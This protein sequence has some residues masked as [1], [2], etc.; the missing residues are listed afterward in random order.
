MSN[1]G[2]RFETKSRVK[3]LRTSLIFVTAA[4]ITLAATNSR[5]LSENDSGGFLYSHYLQHQTGE[6]ETFV[7][8]SPSSPRSPFWQNAASRVKHSVNELSLSD[9][10]A[11]QAF[12]GEHSHTQ[13]ELTDLG[14]QLG[15]DVI[16]QGALSAADELA[17]D[18]L[19]QIDVNIE[20]KSGRGFSNIG[21]DAITSLRE[22][23]KDVLAAQV[24]GYAGFDDNRR[25]GFNVGS[26]YRWVAND[27]TLLGANV[28][29]DYETFDGDGFWRLGAGA[30]SRSAWLDVFG[31]VY[32]AQTDTKIKDNGD[33]IYSASGYDVEAHVHSPKL[34]L[35]A[36]VVGAYNWKG[37]QG[38]SNEDGFLLGARVTPLQIPLLMQVDYRTGE[39][40]SLGGRFVFNY[41]FNKTGT[42]FSHARG[43]VF[44]PQ[45]YFYAPVEREYTQRI[46]VGKSRLPNVARFIGMESGG[47]VLRSA[48]SG[49]TVTV[50]SVANDSMIEL[51]G[52]LDGADLVSSQG[53]AAADRMFDLSTWFPA[54]ANVELDNNSG[55]VIVMA[56]NSDNASRA[57]LSDKAEV[58]VSE[59][60]MV[61]EQG[62]VSIQANE[63]FNL[64][65]GT[66]GTPAGIRIREQSVIE[67][68]RATNGAGQIMI[69]GSFVV[70]T[71]AMTISSIGNAAVSLRYNQSGD[72]MGN[73]TSISG[74]YRISQNGVTSNVDCDSPGTF[75]VNGPLAVMAA[76]SFPG[77]GT[78]NSPINAPLGYGGVIATVSGTGTSNASDE[79][80]AALSSPLTVNEN[81]VISVADN[82]TLS[83]GVHGIQIMLTRD[84]VLATSMVYVFVGEF[85]ASL[86]P[87]NGD[88]VTGQSTAN[89][90]F[91]FPINDSETAAQ[92]TRLARVSARGGNDVQY[93]YD[94]K[95][96]A[97]TASMFEVRN[98]FLEVAQNL[99]S[100]TTLTI[101]VEVSTN[102][103]NS[104]SP[105]DPA[106]EF[107][108]VVVVADI[109]FE[110]VVQT[111]LPGR[112]TST[113]PYRIEDSALLEVGSTLAIV[114]ASGAGSV[115]YDFSRN[116][117][118]IYDVGNG[119][120]SVAAE[121]DG[122]GSYTITVRATL[123]SSSSTMITMTVLYF[124]GLVAGASVENS[125][126]IA[127]AVSD[128]LANNQNYGSFI[129]ADGERVSV[130]RFDESK[131]RSG[132]L[133][134]D[135]V[136]SMKTDMIGFGH[137]N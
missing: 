85:A 31:N 86:T 133:L 63:G 94:I 101:I 55:T 123:T 129:V 3:T 109:P 27:N 120:V 88:G 1:I 37:K 122:G 116:S 128:E 110:L 75:C 84:G 17:G 14:S 21:L 50:V 96:A 112:G 57:E 4:V 51:R 132:A 39:G 107:A 28:F 25:H 60:A 126:F 35:L 20:T 130:S 41:E 48:E 65:M 13:Q 93:A 45:N 49:T 73:V 114:R 16:R 30:E 99:P 113:N 66:S 46:Q 40:E 11:K 18:W 7:I 117:N 97:A 72:L 36:G 95:G 5:A 136:I 24:H 131:L 124:R 33:A 76:S 81:G 89:N 69:A 118:I 53:L 83:A 103:S 34:P 44:R 134:N 115:S 137:S 74:A 111:N 104:N 108:V 64:M 98:G 15:A 121:L 119:V 12:N 47:A 2:M 92:G 79:I 32:S 9:I 62:Q 59:N 61:L 68:N 87:F 67:V 127:P 102:N 80:A 42:T 82:E 43:G 105:N 29:L 91:L 58:I 90:A 52:F 125:P 8:S 56:W 77:A 106:R 38:E 100:D 23:D 19:R 26:I 54:G 10:L 71:D 6:S 70:T 135:Y 22:T 78:S